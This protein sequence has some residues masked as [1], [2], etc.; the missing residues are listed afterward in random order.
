[1]IRV[2]FGRFELQSVK[3]DEWKEKVASLEAGHPSFAV[4]HLL[5]GIA[6]FNSESEQTGIIFSR[7]KSEFLFCSLLGLLPKPF[8]EELL[9]DFGLVLPSISK[10]LLELQMSYLTQVKFITKSIL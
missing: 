7:M 6:N 5:V 3:K 2:S 9:K 4:K 8:T 10:E 1:M